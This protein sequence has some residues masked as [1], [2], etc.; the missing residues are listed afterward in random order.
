MVLMQGFPLVPSASLLGLVGHLGRCHGIDHGD[1]LVSPAAKHGGVCAEAQICRCGACPAADRQ[2]PLCLVYAP[3]QNKGS[4]AGGQGR[5]GRNGVSQVHQNVPEH[6]PGLK[7]HQRRHLDPGQ[8][9]REQQGRHQ[10]RPQQN[11][12]GH[13][14]AMDEARCSLDACGQRL[15]DQSRGRVLPVAQLHRRRTTQEAIFPQHRLPGELTL[16]DGDDYGHPQVHSNGWRHSTATGRF[17]Q[18]GGLSPSSDRPQREGAARLDRGAWDD[19]QE[20]GIGVGKV[21]EKSRPVAIHPTDHNA[22]P[23]V[24]QE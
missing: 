24:P 6:F 4:A 16:P 12:L 19:G 9:R 15:P 2:W 11:L 14:A 7:C 3:D 21:F 1:L 20:I 17:W 18:I 22:V 10:R 13:D 23:K 5:H 8:H